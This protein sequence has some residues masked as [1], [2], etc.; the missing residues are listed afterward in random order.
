MSDVYPMELTG[1]P[2]ALEFQSARMLTTADAMENAGRQ[3]RDLRTELFRSLAVDAIAGE[4]AEASENVSVAHGRY[5]TAGSALRDYARELARVQALT[6]N[7]HEQATRASDLRAGLQA[8]VDQLLPT[9]MAPGPEQASA[10]E[11]IRALNAEIQQFDHEA[12]MLFARWQGYLGEK[13]Q[14]AIA[15]ANRIERGNERSGLNDSFWDNLGGTLSAIVDVVLIIARVLRVVLRIISLILTVLAVVFTVLG[16]IFPPFAAVG[17][18]LF[19]YARIVDLYAA[20]LGL[21]IAI[22]EGFNFLDMLVAV[23]GIALSAAGGQLGSMAGAFVGSAVGGAL[24]G[25]GAAGQLAAQAAARGVQ[26]LVQAG[27]DAIVDQVL[28]WSDGAAELYDMLEPFAGDLIDDVAG[29]AFGELTDGFGGLGGELGSGLAPGVDAIAG[30][31]IGDVGATISEQYDAAAGVLD[32]ML[33]GGGRDVLDAFGVSLG[34]DTGRAILDNALDGSLGAVGIG[35][36]GTAPQ[37]DPMRGSV[38]QFVMNARDAATNGD[39]V[40]T[41]VGGGRDD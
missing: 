21:I 1:D 34:G 37:I 29:G 20:I 36:G 5:R 16:A 23:L 2:D 13:H 31:G 19:T 6:R 9:A 22:L 12:A 4:A 40:V 28:D 33:D 27:T 38:A 24:A 7:I 32:G 15:A 39:A 17:A 35:A 8:Q 18:L 3:L 10:I 30:S 11:R 14:A 25:L 41:I 26:E